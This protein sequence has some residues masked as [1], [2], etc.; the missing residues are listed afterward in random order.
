MAALGEAPP[1]AQGSPVSQRSWRQ[2]PPLQRAGTAGSVGTL[3][4]KAL[5]APEA[6]R[7][8]P[9]PL[10]QVAPPQGSD[11][12][13]QA[14]GSDLHPTGGCP[15]NRG[16]PLGAK[17]L[18]TAAPPA[19]TAQWL[20]P[21][22]QGPFPGRQGHR[23]GPG[24]L[25]MERGQGEPI[26]GWGQSGIPVGPLQIP[27]LLEGLQPGASLAGSTGQTDWGSHWGP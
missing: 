17:G 21:G 8:W 12:P 20:R 19:P 25:K 4:P 1:P 2:S 13:G 14:P 3:E 27:C 7:D 26:L 11:P 18:Y 10:G 6:R 23:A 5:A 9:P 16:P 24:L 15:Q 22:R